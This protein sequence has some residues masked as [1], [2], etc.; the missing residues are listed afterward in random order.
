[1][2]NTVPAQTES[3]ACRQASDPVMQHIHG[4]TEEGIKVARNSGNKYP[5]VYRRIAA[6]A[7]TN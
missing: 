6:P 1:M 7:P 2:L 4:S 5:A 3:N